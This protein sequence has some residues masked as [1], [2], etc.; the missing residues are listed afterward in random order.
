MPA[1]CIAFVL[2][3]CCSTTLRTSNP[4]AML[5]NGFL[6]SFFADLVGQCIQKRFGEA[7]ATVWRL[8]QQ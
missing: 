2:F 1:I 7:A 6:N 5:L 4:D 3:S 8:Q